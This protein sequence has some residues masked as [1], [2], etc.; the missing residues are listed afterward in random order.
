MAILN[1]YRPA[2]EGL[3]L[4]EL[5]RR[6]RLAKP[7]VYR[8]LHE[9]ADWG[10]V[11]RCGNE[12]YLGIQL[13]ELGQMATRQRDLRDAA[14]P[15]LSDL[16]EVTHET[17]HLAILDGTEVVYIEKLARTGAPEL[18]SR[19]GGRMQLHCTGVGKALLAYSDQLFDALV[20]SG[21]HRRTPH[22][23][24]APGILLNQLIETR[25]SGIAYDREESTAGVT[26]VAAV[27]LDKHERPAGAI[28]ISGWSTHLKG[29]R[30]ESL[31]QA[32]SLAI[33]RHLRSPAPTP[34][35][36][37]FSVR[38]GRLAKPAAPRA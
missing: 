35:S 25:R 22:T 6:S 23:I 34:A 8:L 14:M 26:C 9:L 10:V 12:W 32:A 31:V 28:S 11:E 33:S 19:V 24:V 5:T 2:D 36:E 29:G 37:R 38:N 15:F 13:F 20:T 21:L 18:P 16:H 7:T 3:S 17:V 1:C 30:P 4:A 27:V